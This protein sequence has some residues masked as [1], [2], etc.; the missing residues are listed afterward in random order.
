MKH[1]QLLT[2]AFR[3]TD[4]QFFIFSMGVFETSVFVHESAAKFVQ[5]VFHDKECVA[6][7]KNLSCITLNLPDDNAESPG[8]YYSILKRIA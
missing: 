7:N 3:E 1:L 8:Y 5:E 2:Q 4:T 6:S